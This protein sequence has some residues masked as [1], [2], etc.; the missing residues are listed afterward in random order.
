MYKNVIGD[1]I[2]TSFLVS[3][4]PDVSLSKLKDE[5]YQI[6]DNF[7]TKNVSNINGYHSPVF[8]DVEPCDKEIYSEIYKLEDTF[9]H[10]SNDYLKSKHYDVKLCHFQWWVNI[11]PPNSYNVLHNHKRA[12]IIGVYYIQCDDEK[13]QLAIIRNDGSQYGNLYYNKPNELELNVPL[14]KGRMYIM[15]G[16]LFHYVFTNFEKTDRISIAFN[17]FVTP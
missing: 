5:C 3:C 9:L 2:F 1:T 13:S 12:D 14:I 7:P 15:P 4:E 16:H 17:L 10:F 6:K 8:T 11:S